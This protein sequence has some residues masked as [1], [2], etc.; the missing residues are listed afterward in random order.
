MPSWACVFLLI[1][2]LD[3]NKWIL[4]LWIQNSSNIV[5]I[6]LSNSW[7]V[8][9]GSL[10][11]RARLFQGLL[12]SCMA[13]P[14]EWLIPWWVEYLLPPIVRSWNGTQ[15]LSKCCLVFSVS[16][17][18]LSMFLHQEMF[19]TMKCGWVRESSPNRT[20]TS[21]EFSGILTPKKECGSGKAWWGPDTHTETL[22][23]RE[24]WYAVGIVMNSG[25]QW[26]GCLLVVRWGN[27]VAISWSYIFCKSAPIQAD[28]FNTI[29]DPLTQQNPHMSRQITSMYCNYSTL[30]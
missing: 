27:N 1:C 28:G 19:T 26:Y 4:E 21:A 18:A 15:L 13:A 7:T 14:I 29:K 25:L 17:R 2:G 5:R 3:W 11:S 16:S 8:N 23:I 10:L 9:L 6:S 24:N 20:K 22:K 30:R 12:Y